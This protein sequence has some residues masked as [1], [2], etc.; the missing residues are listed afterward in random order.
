MSEIQNNG[1]DLKWGKGEPTV[2]LN[3]IFSQREKKREKE[4]ESQKRRYV[5]GEESGARGSSR[6]GVERGRL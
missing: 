5:K 4:G 3:P 2:G 1:R 6:A